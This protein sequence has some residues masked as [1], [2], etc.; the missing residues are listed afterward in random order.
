[1]K[2]YTLTPLDT[3]FFRDGRP[4]NQ[5]EM[6][7]DDL[8][9]QF[10][11][12]VSTLVGSMRAALA[13]NHDWSGNGEWSAEIKQALGDGTELNGLCF[14]G[15][16][17][18][19]NDEP[20][21]AAPAHL[22]GHPDDTGWI[23][24]TRMK[25]GQG[26]DCDLGK[27]IRLPVADKPKEGLKELA[28]SWLTLKGMQQVIDGGIPDTKEIIDT[29]ELWSFENRTGIDRNPDTKVVKD[30]AL[31]SCRHVRIDERE[32]ISVAVT[33]KGIPV[34][35]NPATPSGFGGE[36]RSAWIEQRDKPVP[37][38][39]P[40]VEV[41]GDKVRFTVI[42]NSPVDLPVWPGPGGKLP[43]VP[44]KVVVACIGRPQRVGGW[45]FNKGP[46][47]LK[48]FIPPGSVWFM[49]AESRCADEIMALHG[50]NIGNNKDWGYGQILIGS[51]KEGK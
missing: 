7:L 37:L 31:Y 30:G 40:H 36:G 15:P 21:F 23:D 20:I 24:V 32:N 6:N 42:V 39:A 25:P 19:R 1:M 48:P 10:P 50:T 27:N 18:L 26:L 46:L 29:S 11:P 35:W 3:W 38:P 45:D 2:N 33:I 49:E 44:G 4:F 51:W 13:L 8:T 47:P 14:T 17:V 9:S 5:G 28:H 16:L 12:P 41:A 34:G 22:L 43:G